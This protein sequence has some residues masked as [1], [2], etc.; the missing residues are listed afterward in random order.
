LRT[1]LA[2]QVLI[3]FEE[4]VY[5]VAV[6]MGIADDVRKVSLLQFQNRETQP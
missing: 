6:H 5:V 1:A 2:K 4:G 3:D